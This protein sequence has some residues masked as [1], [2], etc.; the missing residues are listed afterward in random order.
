MSGYLH[1]ESGNLS[2]KSL[3]LDLFHLQICFKFFPFLFWIFLSLWIFK[4]HC[5]LGFWGD[6]LI[7]NIWKKWFLIWPLLLE[8]KSGFMNSWVRESK[9]HKT[10]THKSLKVCF[11]SLASR[12]PW[13]SRVHKSAWLFKA[14][15]EQT[16]TLRVGHIR[17]LT[18]CHTTIFDFFN[19]YHSFYF[20]SKFLHFWP[21]LI[22]P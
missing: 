2:S 19:C 18:H 10:T 8:L 6:F 1:A 13:N 20:F 14:K 17:D 3:G 15:P 21:S 12:S 7:F 5:K 16:Q 9:K 11:V 4:M 22:E